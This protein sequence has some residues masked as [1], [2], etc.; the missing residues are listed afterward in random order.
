MTYRSEML[1]HKTQFKGVL[2]SIKTLYD[3]L[4]IA[5]EKLDEE[6]LDGLVKHML[7]GG[8]PPDEL[9]ERLR[10]E[11]GGNPF[12]TIEAIRALLAEGT[13]YREKD[14]WILKRGP[15]GTIPSSVVELVS[16]RLETLDLDCL[17]IIEYG[18]VLGRRFERNTLPA[19]FSMEE[20][21]VDEL[22]GQLVEQNF[23]QTLGDEL[24]FQHSKIQ[25]VIY[26]SMSDR[27]KRVLHKRAGE[28]LELAYLEDVDPVLFKLAYHYSRTRDYEK[29]I[30]YSISAGY[31]ATNNFAPKEA[32]RFFEGAISL[33]ELCDRE[34]DRCLDI[35]DILGDLYFLDADYEMAIQAYDRLYGM[36][37]D[38]GRH[39]EALMK[40]GRVY[41]SQGDYDNASKFYEDA[42]R[43]AREV[44]SLLLLA[45]INGQ[46]GK[47]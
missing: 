29:G 18:A 36:T 33:I 5:L 9:L 24:Q 27:W 34:D 38:A 6:S 12:F 45:R 8:R 43:L 23:F 30:E 16:R 4:D 21:M 14:I 13:L 35:N 1:E 22:V 41:Q 40:K 2:E 10:T 47:I 28:T 44:D 37:D 39:S 15:E 46:L 20:D 31:K 26:S 42:S 7:E 25:E 19:G 17:R 3:C 32:A 11:T